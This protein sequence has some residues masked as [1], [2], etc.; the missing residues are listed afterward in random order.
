[1]LEMK[2]VASTVYR[3]NLAKLALREIKKFKVGR[4]QY[5]KLN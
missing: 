2:D 4:E 3:F 1:M 5:S